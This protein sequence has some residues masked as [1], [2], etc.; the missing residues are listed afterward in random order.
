MIGR[1]RASVS[2]LLNLLLAGCAGVTVA[3]LPD[4][5]PSGYAAPGLRVFRGGSPYMDFWF[6]GDVATVDAR[7]QP[8]V[9]YTLKPGVLVGV[10]R[11]HQVAVDFRAQKVQ[12]GLYTL[13]YGVQPDDGDHE[14][15]T[16]ARD[17][18]LLCPAAD[19]LS[20]EPLEHKP[21]TKLSA[22]LNGKKHPAVLFLDV[23]GD[24]PLPGV[25]ERREPERTIVEAR[26]GKALRLA[27]VV[28]GQYMD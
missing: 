28:V 7:P 20:T 6:R 19:D 26:V 25:I 2:L 27:I 12:P 11:V 21:L 9:H 15:K 18:L 17:F 14:D 24:G 5:P 23:P 4:P 13:R 10:V 1:A 3:S 8:R 16:E 22:T